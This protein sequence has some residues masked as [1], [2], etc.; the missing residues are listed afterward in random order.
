MSRLRDQSAAQCKNCRP[1]PIGYTD[2]A[3]ICQYTHTDNNIHSD[4][5]LDDIVCYNCAVD[6]VR[7]FIF[8]QTVCSASASNSKRSRRIWSEFCET[9]ESSPGCRLFT[10]LRIR[11]WDHSS[12]KFCIVC[13]TWRVWTGEQQQLEIMETIKQT[14]IQYSSWTQAALAFL[15]IK[16]TEENKITVIDLTISSRIS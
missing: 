8:H 9:C 2:N 16:Q 11:I 7:L 4:I 13:I 1:V 5:V 15:P 3:W 14:N 12:R 10:R 6:N